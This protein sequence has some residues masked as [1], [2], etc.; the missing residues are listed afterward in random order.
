MVVPPMLPWHLAV[1]DGFGNLSPS[2]AIGK[3]M[4]TVVPMPG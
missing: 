2:A 1:W 3:S 4:V